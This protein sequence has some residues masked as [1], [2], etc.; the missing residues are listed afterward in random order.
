[1]LG[2]GAFTQFPTVNS[3]NITRF[4]LK[5]SYPLNANTWRGVAMNTAGTLSATNAVTLTAYVI[6]TQ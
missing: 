5:G 6:C 3:N 4:Q 1:M 2:G